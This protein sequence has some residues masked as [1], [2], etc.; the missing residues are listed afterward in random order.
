MKKIY[1][2]FILA[3]A[4]A[5]ALSACQTVHEK[6]EPL[7]DISKI[8]ISESGGYGGINNDFFM[9]ISEKK[10]ISGIEGVIKRANGKK[11][12]VDVSDDKP[13]YDLLINY[14]DGGTHLLQLVLGSEGEESIFTYVGHEKNGFYV[15]PEDTKL[16]RDSLEL[17]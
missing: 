1:L 2:L 10:T 7:D 6:I 15:S 14:A 11:H 8:S 3:L 17:Q 4:L 13:D 5:L 16:L 9:T 12:V